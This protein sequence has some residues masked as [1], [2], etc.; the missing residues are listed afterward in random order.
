ML[1][2]YGIMDN[3]VLTVHV[4]EAEDLRATESE[5]NSTSLELNIGGTIVEPYVILAI[6][7]QKIET[8]PVHNNPAKPIWDEKFTF[9]IPT[10]Q[11]D[12]Q[13]LVVNKD[14]FA[15]NDLIGKCFIPLSLL[16]D[17][18]KHEDWFELENPN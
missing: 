8:K 11:E 12:L 5:G 2:Q 17:Q 16:Q 15:T 3:S 7:N 18:M 10:G 6:E 13:V 4:M 14:V 9:E 1:N